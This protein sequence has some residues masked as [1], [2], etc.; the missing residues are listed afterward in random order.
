LAVNKEPNCITTRL[1]GEGGWNPCRA[2]LD[3]EAAVTVVGTVAETSV[4][5]YHSL[6]I[7]RTH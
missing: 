3:A 7:V 6:C 1:Y 4:C 5:N 2:A